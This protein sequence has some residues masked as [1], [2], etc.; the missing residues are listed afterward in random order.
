[1]QI[2]LLALWIVR[3]MALQY[4]LNLDAPIKTPDLKSIVNEACK[5]YGAVH[6]L[7]HFFE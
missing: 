7:L 6:Q 5:L 4:R 3:K 2:L 1:M